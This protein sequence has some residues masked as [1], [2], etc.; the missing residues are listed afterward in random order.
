MSAPHKK[1]RVG[2]LRPSQLL[3]HGHG[4]GRLGDD[5]HQRDR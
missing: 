5:P 3:D 1:Y 4:S 2:E